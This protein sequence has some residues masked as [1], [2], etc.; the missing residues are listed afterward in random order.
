MN[1]DGKKLRRWCKMCMAAFILL[2]LILAEL[3]YSNLA[4]STARYAVRSS[5]LASPIRVVFLSD[6]HEREFGKD[7]CRLLEKIAAEQPDIIALVGDFIDEN[8]D[9]SELARVCGFISAAGDIAPVYFGMGNHEYNYNEKNGAAIEESIA[10]AGARVLEGEYEEIELRGSKL[11]VGGYAGYYRT[12]QMDSEAPE[13]RAAAHAFFADFEDTE[14]FKLLLDHIPT[15]WLD[16]EYRDVAPVD[17]VLSGHYHGGIVRIPF[18]GQGLF[19]PYVGWFPP[20]TKGCFEGEK[21]TCILTTGL[22]GAGG[23]PRFFNPPEIVVVEL[24]PGGTEQ[25]AP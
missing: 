4:L 3:F 17:L 12:P 24:L 10:Q 23:F 8:A 19:A 20:Y 9:E 18:I 7:N 2:V 5:K 13:K 16:W 25:K 14:S 11:R 6:L 15:T 21:A 22:A 1:R